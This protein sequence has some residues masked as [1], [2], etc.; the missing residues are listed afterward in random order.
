MDDTRDAEYAER[1]IQLGGRRWKQLLNVQ[2]VYRWSI[3]RYQLGRTL[4]IGSGIGR[5]LAAL[6]AGSVGVD[7]N[8]ASVKEARRRGYVAYT[9]EEFFAGDPEG[10]F[11]ALLIAHVVEHL[12][13]QEALDVL[14]MYLPL[15]RPGGRVLFICP[16][17][18]AT[19]RIRHMCAGR[20]LRISGSS[21]ATWV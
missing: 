7:H 13:A 1:L 10:V 6:P 3:R 15:L 11:D 12:S 18:G 9:V 16:Q 21:L 14:G 17:R 2:A 5:N 20:P 4:D 8:A 19:R